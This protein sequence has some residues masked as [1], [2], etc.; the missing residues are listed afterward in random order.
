MSTGMAVSNVVAAGFS[1]HV[2]AAN[3]VC[4]RLSSMGIMLVMGMAQGCQPLMGFSYG[5]RNFKR[6]FDTLKNALIFSTAI[7]LVIGAVLFTFADS[8]IKV[9]IINAD[10]VA[11]GAKLMRLMV[12][13]MPFIGVQMMLRTLFQSLG[14]SVEA[15]ILSLGRQGLFFI[16]ALLILSRLFGETGFMLSMPT[17]DLLTTLLAIVLMIFLRKKLRL[18]QNEIKEAHV[19]QDV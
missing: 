7:T 13:V 16:P 11:K 5:S 6:L 3:A 18:M 14:R 1:D 9:F 2:V 8:W 15:L 4:M 10:V 12:L 17:A 19:G